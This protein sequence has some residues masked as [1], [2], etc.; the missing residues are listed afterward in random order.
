M[1]IFVLY[2]EVEFVWTLV[3]DIGY[4]LNKCIIRK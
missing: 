4:D 2:V 1:I 3:Y